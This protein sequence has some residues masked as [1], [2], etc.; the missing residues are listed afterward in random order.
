MLN[1][2]FLIHN[3]IFTNMIQKIY[4]TKHPSLFKK[5][6]IRNTHFCEEREGDGLFRS[7]AFREAL[8]ILLVTPVSVLNGENYPAT[9][10]KHHY[11]FVN[12]K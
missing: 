8:V 9:D 2:H 11:L 12:Y 7:T 10:N 3:K 5:I 4:C 6:V 1:K